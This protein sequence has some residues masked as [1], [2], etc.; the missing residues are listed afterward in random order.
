LPID[1]MSE[2]CRGP[3]IAV[4]VFPYQRKKEQPSN[5]RERLFAFLKKYRLFSP[6]GPW[7]FDVLMH[8]T[9]AGSQRTTALSLKRYPPALYL[10]PDVGTYRVLDWRAHEALFDAGYAC[11]KRALDSGAL[12]RS[13]WEGRSPR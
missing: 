11:A 13:L 7:L 12:P 2:L 5:G 9:L 3:I 4:D 10:A 1:I 6:A 8:A